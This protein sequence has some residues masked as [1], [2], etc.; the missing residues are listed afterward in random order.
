MPML[1]RMSIYPSLLDAILQSFAI[2][3]LTFASLSKS[4]DLLLHT[5][6]TLG[7]QATKLI[8]SYLSDPLFVVP[9]SLKII[10]V[11]TQIN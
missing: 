6:T 2:N 3:F 10:K 1:C 9:L 5:C 4:Q 7:K 11:S 8:S